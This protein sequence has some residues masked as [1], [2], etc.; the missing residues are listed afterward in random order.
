MNMFTQNLYER[1][2]VKGWFHRFL[3][4][5][6]GREAHLLSLEVVRSAYVSR[7]S[8]YAGAKPIPIA[9]IRGSENR[10]QDFDADF[11]PL[12]NHVKT[13]WM[14]IAAVWQ[15]NVTLPPV[16]LIQVG[17]DYFVMDGHHRISVAREMGQKY[18]DATVTT[19]RVD[20]DSVIQTAVTDPPGS[21]KEKNHG[22]R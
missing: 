6:A 8:S 7:N 16:E 19:W 22:E 11:H 13:R 9:R 14:K 1:A 18:I 20:D 3:A 17:E 4:R 15:F 21:R 10:T 5:L 2:R 12:S